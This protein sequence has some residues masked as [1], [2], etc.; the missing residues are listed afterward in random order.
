M[1]F[2]SRANQ[3]KPEALSSCSEQLPETAS[4][5]RVTADLRPHVC[6]DFLSEIFLS[7]PGSDHAPSRNTVLNLDCAAAWPGI[8][9]PIMYGNHVDATTR[10]RRLRTKSGRTQYP[11]A[12]RGEQEKLG[13]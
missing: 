10:E 2:G 7:M 1:S 4:F 8:T 13:D 6:G 12:C 5:L 3:A 11:W 9:H